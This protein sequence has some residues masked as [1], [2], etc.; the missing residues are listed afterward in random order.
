MYVAEGKE[1]KQRKILVQ[2][3]LLISNFFMGS[4]VYFNVYT[5]WPQIDYDLALIF[6]GKLVS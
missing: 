6:I 4:H 2:P 3:L 5:T 1:D